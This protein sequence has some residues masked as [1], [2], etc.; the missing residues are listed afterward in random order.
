MVTSKVLNTPKA[1]AIV[2]SASMGL[3]GLMAYGVELNMPMKIA[4]IAGSGAL[5]WAA[6]GWATL[7]RP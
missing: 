1:F 7:R 2:S 5:V 3:A 6:A 4:A